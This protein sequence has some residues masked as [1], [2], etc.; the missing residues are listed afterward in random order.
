MF[1]LFLDFLSQP[2]TFI[3]HTLHEKD[4]FLNKLHRQEYRADNYS[5]D[6]SVLIET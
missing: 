2:H 5:P 3:F 4:S 1:Q 6:V